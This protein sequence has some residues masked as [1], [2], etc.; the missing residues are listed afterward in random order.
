MAAQ[1]NTFQFPTINIYNEI[2]DH[3]IQYIHDHIINIFIYAMKACC[4]QWSQDWQSVVSEYNL[5]K[6]HS[7]FTLAMDTNKCEKEFNYANDRSNK[8][9]SNYYTVTD[10]QFHC[11]LY[12]ILSLMRNEIFDAN[13]KI[14]H[15]FLYLIRKFD[16]NNINYINKMFIKYEG[17]DKFMNY[18]KIKS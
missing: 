4:Q 7:I 2:L 13:N 8:F 15:D 5:L 9:L 11:R 17:F 12:Y 6:N 3:N 18:L 16:N 14:H 1:N 10:F